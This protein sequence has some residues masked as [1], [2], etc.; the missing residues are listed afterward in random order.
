MPRTRASR[1]RYGLPICSHVARGRGLGAHTAMEMAASLAGL[2]ARKP[3][4]VKL[5]L[6]EVAYDAMKTTEL[7]V[8]IA[9]AAVST[10][11]ADVA[12]D[13][14]AHTGAFISAL[15]P[16]VTPPPPNERKPPTRRQV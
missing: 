8:P 6:G 14:K 13:R 15:S 9:A 1:S 7:D 16:R 5:S 11:G 3:T 10:W 2:I 4:L 12:A